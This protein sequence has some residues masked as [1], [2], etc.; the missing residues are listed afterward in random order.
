M[1]NLV[2][3]YAETRDPLTNELEKYISLGLISKFDG[4]GILKYGR[5]FCKIILV[6]D[7]SGSMGE[8]F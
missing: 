7:I 8:G 3:G 1:L 4:N 6:L 2:S 5:P